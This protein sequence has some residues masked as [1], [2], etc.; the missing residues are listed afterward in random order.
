MNWYENRRLLLGPVAVLLG[1]ASLGS[2]SAEAAPVTVSGT[3]LCPTGMPV[4]GVWVQSS[5]GGSRFAKREPA[6]SVTAMSVYS[7]RVSSGAV[8]LHVGCGG[9]PA[10]WGSDQWT[11]AIRVTRSRS[12]NATCTGRVGTFRRVACAFPARP[13]IA[14]PTTNGFAKGN[15]T[16]YAADKW[17]AATGHYP[18]WRGHALAWNENAASQRWTVLSIPAAR[19]VVVFE[20]GVQ[21]SH[22]TF[23]HVAW[24][25][26]VRRRSDGW[27]LTVSEMNF[28][29]AGQVTSRTV[30]HVRGMS[31]I[32][33]P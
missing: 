33:A 32:W 11:A 9:T 10:K 25:E 28:P 18:S 24:V 2:V 15:C 17:R 29:V 5:G 19:S 13:N 6:T 8:E 30:K 21:G 14:A 20:P 22:P 4:V 26:S 7:A 27:Y 23:G 1:F 31:Y 3:V 12:L 16:Q